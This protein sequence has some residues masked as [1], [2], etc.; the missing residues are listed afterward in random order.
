LTKPTK[1]Q[2]A[3]AVPVP[4]DCFLGLRHYFEVLRAKKVKLQH[5]SNM[6]KENYPGRGKGK[7]GKKLMLKGSVK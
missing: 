2:L 3:I 5:E 1:Y 4:D 7:K 6:H